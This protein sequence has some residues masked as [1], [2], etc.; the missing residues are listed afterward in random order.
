MIGPS[1]SRECRVKLGARSQTLDL[2]LDPQF[3][4]C[5]HP[6]VKKTEKKRR[7]RGGGEEEEEMRRRRRGGEEEEEGTKDG[8][9]GLWLPLLMLCQRPKS[10]EG[11][12]LSIPTSELCESWLITSP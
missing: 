5:I 12:F 2:C 8:A 6:N 10:T 3:E 4:K 9:A 11:E 7:R 1:L